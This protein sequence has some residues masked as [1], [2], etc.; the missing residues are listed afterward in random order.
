MKTKTKSKNLKKSRAMKLFQTCESK[1]RAK[2]MK[3]NAGFYCPH[4]DSN[5]DIEELVSDD[6][7]DYVCP[8]CSEAIDHDPMEFY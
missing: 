8:G 7:S 4:C 5:W 2:L 6:F 3:D 1:I